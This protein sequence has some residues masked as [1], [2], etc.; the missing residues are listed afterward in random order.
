LGR[1]ES[2]LSYD[3]LKQAGVDLATRE[4]YDAAIRRMN[5]LLD[6]LQSLLQHPQ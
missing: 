2:D 6:Q 1:G 4:P 3:L 5:K